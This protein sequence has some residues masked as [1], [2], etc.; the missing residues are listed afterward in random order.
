MT[1][2]LRFP[3]WYKQDIA[4]ISRIKASFPALNLGQI[5]EKGI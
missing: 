2:R 5:K 1:R 4:F 3:L